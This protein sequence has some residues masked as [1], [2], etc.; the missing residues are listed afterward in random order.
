MVGSGQW[1][2]PDGGQWTVDGGRWAVPNNGRWMVGSDCEQW[3]ISLVSGWDLTCTT[4][5]V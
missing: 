5:N 4:E 2:V 1:V 3:V